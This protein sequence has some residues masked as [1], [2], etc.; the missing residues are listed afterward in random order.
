MPNE[1]CAAANGKGRGWTRMRERE[2]RGSFG[3]QGLIPFSL[4][5][6]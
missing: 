2:Q 4:Q 5:I 3:K 6:G 1:T